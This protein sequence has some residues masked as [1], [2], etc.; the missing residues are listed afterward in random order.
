MG[1]ISQT[2]VL[3]PGYWNN[4]RRNVI[5]AIFEL[6]G[7]D[8]KVWWRWAF[9]FCGSVHRQTGGD[10]I[11]CLLAQPLATRKHCLFPFTHTQSVSFRSPGQ[12][13]QCS[14]SP[15]PSFSFP[16]ILS[17]FFLFMWLSSHRLRTTIFLPLLHKDCDVRYY[18]AFQAR[19]CPLC[20]W[21]CSSWAERP[22]CILSLPSSFHWYQSCNLGSVWQWSFQCMD[23]LCRLFVEEEEVPVFTASFNKNN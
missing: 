1:L 18:I 19:F 4:K 22:V 11:E 7:C 12:E 5:T 17:F 16:S 15:F 2:N 21:H 13:A 14:F 23:F 8:W 6:W 10:W 3:P 9:L 20:N